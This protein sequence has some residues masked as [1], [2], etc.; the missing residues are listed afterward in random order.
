MTTHTI[1]ERFAFLLISILGGG[2]L[3]KEHECIFIFPSW[4]PFT[5][6]YAIEVFIYY[7]IM[8]NTVNNSSTLTA[9]AY[10]QAIGPTHSL[11]LMKRTLYGFSLSSRWCTGLTMAGMYVVTG[12]LEELLIQLCITA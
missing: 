12:N 2:H 4:S 10:I 7:T 3:T 1:N 5:E 6:E 11:E 9:S 8:H